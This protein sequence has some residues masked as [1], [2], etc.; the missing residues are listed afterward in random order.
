MVTFNAAVCGFHYGSDVRGG[1]GTL[2]Y[3]NL[4]KE[5][6]TEI[7]TSDWEQV[8]NSV[9][10]SHGGMACDTDAALDALQNILFECSEEWLDKRTGIIQKAEKVSLNPSRR[11]DYCLRSL[12]NLVSGT[13][14][15]AVM[16]QESP[17]LSLVWRQVA[18]H[19]RKRSAKGMLNSNRLRS[20]SGQDICNLWGL[21]GWG[22]TWAKREPRIEFDRLKEELPLIR[23]YRS[24]KGVF[25]YSEVLPTYIPLV[26]ETYGAP[27]STSQI[28]SAV[29]SRISPP[30]TR[31]LSVGELADNPADG[32]Q[33]AGFTGCRRLKTYSRKSN[34]SITS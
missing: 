7:T 22:D 16:R 8:L 11:S 17:D 4:L 1:M 14:R 30:L 26:L 12:Q 13:A 2:N 10:S 34:C 6:P 32:S 33:W 31:H 25:D 3:Y 19:L 15:E 18:D 23:S 9:T 24:G 20:K 5:G 29:V 28:C 21:P 27:L